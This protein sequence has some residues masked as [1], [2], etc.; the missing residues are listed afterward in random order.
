[1]KILVTGSAGFIGAAVVQRL[2][3][4]G[5]DV[6]GLDNYNSYYDINLKK[7]RI[8]N[9]RKL[10][11]SKNF[12]QVKGNITNINLIGK[13]FD[14]YQI[15]YVIHLAAQ[16]G[17]RYSMENPL[18]YVNSNIL[19]FTNLLEFS[20]KNKVKHFVYASSSSV[21][22]LNSK[23]PYSVNDATDHPVSLY[24]ATKKSNEL[25]AHS[26][27]HLYN[28]P[29][30][31][32]RFFTV[33]GPWDR[34]DMAMQLFSKAIVKNKKI[35]LFNY[36]NHTRDFTYIDDVV[37]AVNISI[38]KPPN[39]NKNWNSKLPKLGSSSARFKVYNVGSS[40]RVKLKYLVSLLEK[41]FNKKAKINLLPLQPGDV[42]DTYSNSLPIK[43]D[44]KFSSSTNIEDGV[45]KFVIWYKKYYK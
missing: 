7:N 11:N 35:N 41:Y 2:L 19:G 24:A 9:I 21:Y 13:L 38:F 25:I 36:G 27:S 3:L 18:E 37:E 22:G 17:V 10:K 20:R 14:Q 31:G 40:K 29:V 12:N 5:H 30:T 8:K 33:Y 16:A 43:K 44:Y 42:I 6:I 32:L 28:I 23:I 39:K 26:Y 15:E 34:P 45:E 1:M 4:E